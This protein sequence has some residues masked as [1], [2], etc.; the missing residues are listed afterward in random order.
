MS[1][2][3]A[4]FL[5]LSLGFPNPA[6]GLRVQNPVDAGM[7]EK[8]ATAL[9][10]SATGLEEFNPGHGRRMLKRLF[11][12]RRKLLD[13]IGRGERN[14][15]LRFVNLLHTPP[16]EPNDIPGFGAARFL[17]F[18]LPPSAVSA[19][20]AGEPTE[21]RG[22]PFWSQL[23]E[24]GGASR[25]PG[26]I[27]GVD[28]FAPARNAMRRLTYAY[29]DLDFDGG[30]PREKVRLDEEEPILLS[31]LGP[32]QREEFK[33]NR[34]LFLHPGDPNPLV[35]TEQLLKGEAILYRPPPE[36]VQALMEQLRGRYQDRLAAQKI[37]PAR[38]NGFL[39]E[40]FFYPIFIL[41]RD[42]MQLVT[43]FRRWQ[44]QLK[45]G[46]V[47]AEGEILALHLGGA[48]HFED[49]SILAARDLPEKASLKLDSR[50][51]PRVPL[52]G[53]LDKGVPFFPARFEEI[54]DH[55]RVTEDGE[56]ELDVPYFVRLFDEYLSAESRMIRTGA[57]FHALFPDAAD[58]PEAVQAAPVPFS[59]HRS[60][61]SLRG[62]LSR[63]TE[64]DL[65]RLW[66]Q[67][68]AESGDRGPIL[69]AFVGVMAK[70]EYK[71]LA[72]KDELNDLHADIWYNLGAD[73]DDQGDL[74]GA[75]AAFERS[76][77][78][79]PEDLH[80]W[81]S[82]GLAR[83]AQ[84]D[85]SGAATAFERS[86]ELNPEDSGVWSGLGIVRHR[87]GDLSG[88]IAAFEKV[89]QIEPNFPGAADRLAG[90]KRAAGGET[91]IGLEEAGEKIRRALSD[92]T[93]AQI[94]ELRVKGKV[95]G[96]VRGMPSL[97][98]LI[99]TTQG[100]APLTGVLRGRQVIAQSDLLSDKTVAA[101]TKRFGSVQALPRVLSSEAIEALVGR[102][103]QREAQ[104]P[105][106]VVIVDPDTA[107]Q[108]KTLLA[109]RDPQWRIPAVI[110]GVPFG[111]LDTTD[112]ETVL[113]YLLNILA[114]MDSIP[115]RHMERLEATLTLDVQRQT[116]FLSTGA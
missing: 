21:I 68:G 36:S 62:F 52:L 51:D 1:R 25:D 24:A 59:I 7:E 98:R 10:H 8:I 48:M 17:S 77:E 46:A 87:Q 89:L 42:H 105:K 84:R 88:A 75:A 65:Q 92:L 100:A 28:A 64:E 33:R 90:L 2:I 20:L 69:E 80:V 32:E 82:L 101:L 5:S 22:N 11:T 95:V 12:E 29:T 70:E 116:L 58:T 72:G 37:P 30:K 19:F 16:I 60:M 107:E 102:L 14:F 67:T 27:A 3:S 114:Q 83:Y 79:N 106:T 97:V 66:D 40:Q 39:V 115:G 53:G 109:K 112:P 49:L 85:L 93:D 61:F 57:V 45:K 6:L 99:Q 4:L 35:E 26:N 73:R 56:V 43:M 38:V 13:I 86:T 34:I 81:S 104:G 96:D 91:S 78:L 110:L 103:Q 54:M 55:L 94:A 23:L 9:G 71:L 44:G 15:T 31:R 41:L 47:P 113:A 111:L 50:D 18:E 76:T 74:S 108:L 63:L